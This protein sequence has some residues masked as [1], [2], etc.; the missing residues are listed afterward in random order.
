M[1][2]KGK[3]L[4][5][6]RFQWS[7]ALKGSNASKAAH[8]PTDPDSNGRD[9]IKRPSTDG[10]AWHGG[11][12]GRTS[13]HQGGV[14]VALRMSWDRA[15]GAEREGTLF[16]AAGVFTVTKVDGKPGM[17]VMPRPARV[18]S[19]REGGAAERAGLRK[20]MLILRLNG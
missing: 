4:K 11:C 3:G 15:L 14:D 7:I 6:R 17:T 9:T 18:A 8:P 2:P 16:P 10:G 1:P 13:H 12:S 5:G 19:V 20:G